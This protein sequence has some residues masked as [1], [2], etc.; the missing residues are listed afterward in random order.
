MS[1]PVWKLEHGETY[2]CDR[3]L[4]EVDRVLA[5]GEVSEAEFHAQRRL[6]E[7]CF[8]DEASPAEAIR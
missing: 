2:R 3:C 6:C 7:P 1:G 8:A 4:Q 5:E